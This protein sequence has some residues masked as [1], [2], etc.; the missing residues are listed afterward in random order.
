M[1]EDSSVIRISKC[2]VRN[3][4]FEKLDSNGKPFRRWLARV[5]GS[6]TRVLCTICRSQLNCEYKGFQAIWQHTQTVKHLKTVKGESTQLRLTADDA[7]TIEDGGMIVDN[8][9]TTAVAEETRQPPV[10]TLKLTDH[11]DEATRAEIIWTM[12]N[13]SSNFSGKSCDD[14]S[15]T[16]KNMFPKEPA[17]KEFSLAHSKLSYMI[18]DCVGPHFRDVLLS[19]V[20]SSNAHYTL[21]FDETTNEGSYKELQTSLR[22]Y[23]ER[24]RRIQEFHLET[25]FIE[26]GKG[27]TIVKYLLLGLS[28]ANLP[29]ERLI[30]ISRDGPNVNKKVFRLMNAEFKKK[31]QEKN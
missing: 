16:F 11:R 7:M 5:P 28:N 21:C 17:C 30:T 3:D 14:I 25:F 29:I 10:P 6:N 8:D 31:K 19:D 2:K 4:W 22:Y 1:G 15:E 13:V 26:N 20:R 24:K 27:E 18:S 12:K 23:S 9:D